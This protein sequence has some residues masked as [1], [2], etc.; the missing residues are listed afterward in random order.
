[1]ARWGSR[2]GRLLAALAGA[3]LVLA[4]AGCL[5]RLAGGECKT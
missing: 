2:A 5:S 1:M 4:Q 3:V